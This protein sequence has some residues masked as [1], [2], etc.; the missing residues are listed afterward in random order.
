MPKPNQ[1]LSLGLFLNQIRPGSLHLVIHTV[2]D[3]ASLASAGP[4][5]FPS[6]RTNSK[7]GFGPVLHARIRSSVIRDNF[8]D[9]EKG[10]TILAR[11]RSNS[12]LLLLGF[13]GLGPYRRVFGSVSM[14]NDSLIAFEDVLR[15]GR[16]EE[17]GCPADGVF[18]EVWLIS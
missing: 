1:I 11:S 3:K 16:S 8:A 18:G 7:E 15:S 14:L 5:Y 4:A 13:G 10:V 12:E 6:E 2:T 9:L 17:S